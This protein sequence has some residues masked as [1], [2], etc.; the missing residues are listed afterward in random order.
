MTRS[1]GWQVVRD[2]TVIVV[3]I[4]GAAA[5]RTCAEAVRAQAA[6][7]LVV[8]RDG[9]I[10]GME[11]TPVGEALQPNIPSK[12]KRAVEL[13]PTAL[14]A[15]IEDTVAP[16]PGWAEA[17][18]AALEC[19]T[20]FACG[21]PVSIAPGLPAS[22]RALALSE[23]GAFN[24]R[25][26]A[27]PTTALPGCNFAFRRAPLL[28]ALS[29]SDGLVDQITFKQLEGLGGKLIWSPAMRVTFCHAND[30]G[31][32][33][34]TRFQHG[35]IYASSG[36]RSDLAYKAAAAGKA[37]LL[38]PV[39]TM[40]SLCNAAAAERLSAPTLAWLMLQHSA[41][42]A[43]EFVGA[44]LGPSAKGLGEWQ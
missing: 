1:S 20:S 18:T 31:A 39:L 21:G 19:T 8:R 34:A 32:R 22:S 17:L 12:R 29:G 13:A 15:L 10:A 4:A 30:E 38:P 33:L 40:R 23:Y 42:A 11:G 28:E 41:W 14:V 6:N 44:V 24:D 2:L 26:P 9:S 7:V 5:L 16:A 36:Q 25:K 43:G 37:L 3:E 35:R 27:G